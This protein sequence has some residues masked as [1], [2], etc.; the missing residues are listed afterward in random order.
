MFSIYRSRVEQTQTPARPFP[1][2]RALC[3][4]AGTKLPAMMEKKTRRENS[5]GA[6]K[7]KK[8]KNVEKQQQ[9]KYT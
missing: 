3:W 5:D 2:V 9:D 4:T 6:L 7:G 1:L 8:Q